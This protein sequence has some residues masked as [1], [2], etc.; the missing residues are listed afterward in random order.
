M[1]N[2][3]IVREL[4]RFAR[5]AVGADPAYAVPWPDHPQ[6]APRA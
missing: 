1:G 6:A 2:A 4:L 5:V 3:G